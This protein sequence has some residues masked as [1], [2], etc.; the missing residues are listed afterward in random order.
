MSRVHKPVN[1]LS[2]AAFFACHLISPE[3]TLH[4]YLPQVTARGDAG[5]QPG[6]TPWTTR[7]AI[8]LAHSLNPPHRPPL[9]RHIEQLHYVGKNDKNVPPE[10]LK[11]A[12]RQQQNVRILVLDDVGHQQGRDNYWTKILQTIEFSGRSYE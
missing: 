12:V 1:L 7:Q 9:S 10:M 6:H 11:A 8:A 4:A 3:L 2:L 5:R